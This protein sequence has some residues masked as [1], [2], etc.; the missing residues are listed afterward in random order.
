MD[1]KRIVI[2][3]A[4]GQTGKQL[5]KQALEGGYRVTAIARNPESLRDFKQ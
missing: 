3:G 4:T 2:F 5:L 1:I